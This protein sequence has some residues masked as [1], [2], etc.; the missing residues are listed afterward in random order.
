MSIIKALISQD[1]I[2]KQ[3]QII[4]L[5]NVLDLTFFLFYDEQKVQNNQ[6]FFILILETTQMSITDNCD[7]FNAFVP[8]TNI[9]IL[10]KN[11][12]LN[13]KH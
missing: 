10:K 11:Y 4:I 13:G 3:G 5:E 1:S 8:N 7:P 12:I 6:F 9:N 2:C